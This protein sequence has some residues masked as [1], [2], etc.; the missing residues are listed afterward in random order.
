MAALPPEYL[1]PNTPPDVVVTDLLRPRV[2]DPTL[3]V[4]LGPRDPDV[5][6]PPTDPVHR[7]VTVGSPSWCARSRRSTRG[8]SSSPQCP[9]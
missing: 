1:D 8:A 9:T 2:D 7:L 4:Q 3:G 6:A 5:P